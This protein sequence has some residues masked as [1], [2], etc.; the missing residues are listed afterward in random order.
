M[1]TNSKTKG[2]AVIGAGI[3]FKNHAKAL[4][5][6][7][8]RARL[9][10]VAELDASKRSAASGNAFVPIV[11]ADY[12]ELLARDDVDIVS[13]CT[14]PSVHEK[15]VV[16]AL[17]AG[18]YVIC[19][20]PLA[21]SLATVDR[22][23]EASKEHPNKLG[24]VYQLRYL[25]EIQ[26]IIRLRDEGSLGKLLFGNFQR[27]G[28]LNKSQAGIEWWGSWGTAGGG[29]VATQ[30][31]HLLDLM[32]YIYG[33]AIEVQAWMSTLK[34]PIQ[35]EDTFT[36]TVHFENGATVSAVASLTAQ[37]SVLMSLD[38]FGEKVSVHY[39]WNLRSTDKES[40]QKAAKT[41]GRSIKLG[42][43]KGK[44]DRVL[45]IGK[46]VA[47]RYFNTSRPAP[48]PVSHTAYYER[49]LDAIDSN[50]PLPVTPSEARRSVELFTAIYESALTGQ[51][52]S[53]PLDESARFY[54]GITVEDYDGRNTTTTPSIV[55][56]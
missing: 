15:I 33:N 17:A 7:P 45:R 6:I 50:S 30:F 47:A 53:L 36:A 16:D 43:A 25:P 42:R 12:G 14:P 49:V 5:A 2:V 56:A 34:N 1:N 55:T 51:R 44:L 18:K 32:L 52:V 35:S 24:T 38:I 22:M 11:T 46:R 37:H 10:G 21:Q 27:F 54:D 8:S 28:F 3:I 29:V 20:K 4:E 39:P 9:I 13:V 48:P 41:A 23:I 31:I 26:Q 40:L 19:E